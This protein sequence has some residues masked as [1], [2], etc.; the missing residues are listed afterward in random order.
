MVLS[1]NRLH[2]VGA[3]QL[4]CL[5]NRIDQVLRHGLNRSM[6]L[7]ARALVIPF[8]KPNIDLAFSRGRMGTRHCRGFSKLPKQGQTEFNTVILGDS[9]LNT[10]NIW[11]TKQ[12]ISLG[13]NLLWSPHRRSRFS[14]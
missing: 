9:L 6:T 2:P 13:S 11:R 5:I 3:N 1:K 4:D 10:A 14:N 8:S 7:E 12:L